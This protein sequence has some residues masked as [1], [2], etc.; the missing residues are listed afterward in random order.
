MLK[1]KKHLLEEIERA[2]GGIVREVFLEVYGCHPA[3]V[4]RMFIK[5]GFGAHA[6]VVD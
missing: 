6:R 1:L 4:A 3:E 5:R 2:S